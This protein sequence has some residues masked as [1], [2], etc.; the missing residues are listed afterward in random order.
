MY[1]YVDRDM[2]EV[3][4]AKQVKGVKLFDMDQKE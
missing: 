2:K 4:S 1:I 3:Y